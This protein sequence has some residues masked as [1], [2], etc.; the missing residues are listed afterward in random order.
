MYWYNEKDYVNIANTV[1]LKNYEISYSQFFNA[2]FLI[3]IFIQ[4]V[5]TKIY[6]INVQS[7]LINE[8]RHSLA[9]FEKKDLKCGNKRF[10]LRCKIRHWET[11][12]VSLFLV[13]LQR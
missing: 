4:T 2:T 12:S 13:G 8:V 5:A 11:I 1:L 10:S 9:N 3:N 7:K 6:I